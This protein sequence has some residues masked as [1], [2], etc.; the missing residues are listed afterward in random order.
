MRYQTPAP[1]TPKMVPVEPKPIPQ[2]AHKM[3]NDP[4]GACEITRAVQGDDHLV[5]QLGGAHR[6]GGVLQHAQ[7]MYARGPAPQ[8]RTARRAGIRQG[9]ATGGGCSATCRLP[10]RFDRMRSMRFCA[11][12]LPEISRYASEDS[13]PTWLGSRDAA[14]SRRGTA[15]SSLVPCS[16]EGI[17]HR[18][19]GTRA[20]ANEV[21]LR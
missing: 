1:V 12:A 9:A 10:R 15:S 17:E 2:C 7:T 18:A 20:P 4:T 19:Q 14:T 3:T 6:S 16:P 13:A 5:Q 11:S 8:R 21:H